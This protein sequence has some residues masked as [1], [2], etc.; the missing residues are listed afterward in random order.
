ML[1]MAWMRLSL[2]LSIKNTI[3]NVSAVVFKRD[4]LLSV[5]EAKIADLAQYRVAGD[6]VTYIE[7][8]RS[9]KIAFSPRS[10]NFHRRHMSGITMSSFNLLQLK[11]IMSVQQK[12]RKD[13]AAPE[14]IIDLA[15]SYSEKLFEQFGLNSSDIPT[16]RQHPELGKLLPPTALIILGMHRSGTSALA[17]VL[18]LLGASLPKNMLPPNAF[19]PKGFFESTEIVALHDELLFGLGSSW[20]DYRPLDPSMFNSAAAA[21]KPRLEA[22]LKDE[23]G[24]S[25]MF[26]V[27]DPRVCRLFPLWRD[28]IGSCGAKA[29]VIIMIRNPIEV[30]YSLKHRDGMSLSHSLNLW[31]RY[32]LDAEFE[33]RRSKRVFVKYD[34]FLSDW[35]RV[36]KRIE[37][38]LDIKFLNF[39]SEMRLAVQEL[40]DPDL[41]HHTVD[42]KIF[43]LAKLD[44]PLVV[45]VFRVLETLIERDSD[46]DALKALDAVRETFDAATMIFSHSSSSDQNFRQTKLG[47]EQNQFG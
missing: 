5:L 25:P 24:N 22:V 31:L 8:L 11:E 46:P 1:T 45:K 42:D 23:Y 35:A 15:V 17:G 3:P 12:V 29:R 40:I 36:V 32:V 16:I 44:N 37:S 18:G 43:D 38:E 30:A 6:W 4:T 33:T 47:L 9:G 13:F 14:A 34:D 2:A 7:V 10:R 19:N 20:Y 39:T 26:V 41:R 27:K 21:I 28:V